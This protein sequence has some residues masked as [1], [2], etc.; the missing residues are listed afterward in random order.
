MTFS[1]INFLNYLYVIFIRLRPYEYTGRIMFSALA[2]GVHVMSVLIFEQF[3]SI[4]LQFVAIISRS[5]SIAS[6]VAPSS[7]ELW[8]LS[9]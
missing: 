7:P 8:T 3:L 4:H 9:W 1:K 5:S 2:G 6:Q